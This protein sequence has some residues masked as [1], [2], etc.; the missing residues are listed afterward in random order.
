MQ[1]FAEKLKKA[2]SYHDVLRIFYGDLLTNEF[3]D[4]MM[5]SQQQTKFYGTSM[6]R[7][8]IGGLS[9][10]MSFAVEQA[11]LEG[12]SSPIMLD[13]EAWYANNHYSATSSRTHAQDGM[14]HHKRGKE[15]KRRKGKKDRTRRK[16]RGKGRKTRKGKIN[17]PGYDH[18]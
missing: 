17:V 7:P 1:Y 6:G 16:G 13:D 3:I 8:R 4:E 10:S 9:D 11:S 14:R 18:S 5:T 2:D 12:I 15:K